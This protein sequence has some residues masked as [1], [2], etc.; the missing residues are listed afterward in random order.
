MF[1]REAPNMAV[2][3]VA[4]GHALYGVLLELD[5]TASNYA[6]PT[7]VVC[8]EDKSEVWHFAS[9]CQPHFGL[10][11]TSYT[12]TSALRAHIMDACQDDDGLVVVEATT[13][14]FNIANHWF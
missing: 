9:L 6:A 13:P 11:C 8:N 7:L 12:H 3:G 2:V 1:A 4:E 10:A 5:K 14:Y